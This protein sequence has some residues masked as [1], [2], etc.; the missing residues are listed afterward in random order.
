MLKKCNKCGFQQDEFLNIAGKKYCKNCNSVIN[1]NSNQMSA[2]D[3]KTAHQLKLALGNLRLMLE[4]LEGFIEKAYIDR[5]PDFRNKRQLYGKTITGDY[6]LENFEETFLTQLLIMAGVCKGEPEFFRN[7]IKKEYYKWISAVGID[8]NNCPDK[9]KHFLF[10]IN[11]VLEDRGEKILEEKEAKIK[12]VK[13]DPKDAV[14][15][16]RDLQNPL[17]KNREERE[18]YK[19]KNWNELGDENR[20]NISDEQGERGREA[21]QQIHREIAPKQGSFS[22]Y[23]PQQRTNSEIIQDV[24]N[25]PQN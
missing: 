6:P 24:K 3:Q 18:N 11:E 17:N 8:Y 14:G 9:L 4:P 20:F 13:F 7:E 21:F 16:F 5:Y 19:G 22:F 12:D 25:N 10:E 1:V 2:Q 23:P 15:L